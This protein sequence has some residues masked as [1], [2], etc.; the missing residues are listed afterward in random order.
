MAIINIKEINKHFT[1]AKSEFNLAIDLAKKNFIVGE[2]KFEKAAAPQ[3]RTRKP[4]TPKEVEIDHIPQKRK[5]GPKPKPIQ[6]ELP[7]TGGGLG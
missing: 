3:K 2:L 7:V 6:Q 1:N 4:R 5:R